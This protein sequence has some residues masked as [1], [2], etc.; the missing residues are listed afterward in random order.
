MQ[1][2][3][4][5]IRSDLEKKN[6][7]SQEKYIDKLEQS[8]YVCNRINGNM[9]NIFSNLFHLYRNDEAFNKLFKEQP[10]FCLPHYRQLLKYGMKFLTKKEFNE[11][12][13]VVYGIEKNYL[14]TLQGDIDWFCKKFDYRF[15]KEEWKNSK[16][17]IERTVYTL[18]GTEPYKKGEIDVY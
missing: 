10:M 2:H 3:L 13:K 11:F 14:E 17:S 15:A 8:C 16:D 1:S 18:T 9:E 4:E 12:Y 7:Q 6:G 5:E